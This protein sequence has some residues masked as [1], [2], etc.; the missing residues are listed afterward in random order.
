MSASEMS[1]AGLHGAVLTAAIAIILEIVG[2]TV[3]AFPEYE[4]GS[5]QN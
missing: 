3:D 1:V 4:M 5:H 2:F